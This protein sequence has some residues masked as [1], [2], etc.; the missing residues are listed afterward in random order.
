VFTGSFLYRPNQHAVD[1][2]LTKIFPQIRQH[3]PTARFLAVG[4]GAKAFF[5]RKVQMEGIEIHDFVPQLRPFI[6]RGTVAV[7]PMTVGTGVSCKLL[8]AF[9]TG[10]PIVSTRMACGDLPVVDG[11]HLFIA[12]E[13]GDFA[14]KVMLLLANAALR[15]TFRENA[16]RLVEESYAWEIV[17]RRLEAILL[18]LQ[19][20]KLISRSEV[21]SDPVPL[22]SPAHN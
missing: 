9:S 4:K 19:Q 3:V 2:F 10:T 18:A 11:K 15:R 14:N 1:F 5:G 17:T 21:L 6:A 16:R 20:R 12:E 8:E 22:I 13:V 7:A